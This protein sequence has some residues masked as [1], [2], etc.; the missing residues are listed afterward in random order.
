MLNKLAARVPGVVAVES[1]VSGTLT[2]PPAKG[3]VP[4]AE[5]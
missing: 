1:T 2:R 4:G 5:R 3:G